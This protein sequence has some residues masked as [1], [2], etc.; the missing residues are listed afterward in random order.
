MYSEKRRREAV[1]LWFELYGTIS[2]EDFVA[3]L[4]YPCAST[5]SRW[6]K[7]DPRHDPD[8][9]RYDS[10]P[11]LTKL[12]AV[13]RV[14]EGASLAQ[15]ARESGLAPSAVW[16]AV[17]RHARGGTAA[18]LPGW[19]G[20]QVAG[21]EKGEGRRP[22]PAMQAP[23]P[24]A[25]GD[26]PDDPAALKAMAEELRMDNAI[27]REVL[28]VLKAACPGPRDLTYAE[29]SLVV[30]RLSDRFPQ[31]ALRLRAGVAKSTYHYNV[32]AMTRPDGPDWLG[33]AVEE[34]FLAEHG[35]RG[36]RVVWE[37]LRRRPEPVRVSEKRVRAKMRERGLEPRGSGRRRPYS[38][39]AGEPDERPANLPLRPDGTHDF[40]PAAP[41]EPWA[42]DIT[43]FRLPDG[44]RKAYLSP[45]ADLFDG[46]P[47][48]WPISPS[49]DAGLANSSLL[50]ACATLR[51][52]ERPAVHADGGCHYRWP[53]WK[54]ICEGRGLTRSMS[55]KG[56][57]P[58]TRRARGSSATSR[59][60]CSSAGTGGACRTRSSPPPWT[61]G[62]GATRRSASRPSARAEGPSTTR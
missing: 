28:D 26:L 45:V 11:V 10:H 12:Q 38:S 48:A 37:R 17:D 55:R 33:D 15:A 35:S 13:S 61:G 27:L 24:A 34:E 53:G 47:V 25:A 62:C 44:P 31:R 22:S 39:Y 58:T 8:R 57:P 54:A 46:K 42:S 9:A 41:N 29:R 20:E 40:S 52:G 59:G 19:K 23:P 5:M 36:Y 50:A 21:G 14:A 56:C 18:L 49:P 51:P 16:R 60:R 43:E 7:A 6:I 2:V 30:F 3:E 1:D 4:G 32:E